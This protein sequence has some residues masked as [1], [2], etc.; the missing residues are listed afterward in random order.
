MQSS[1]AGIETIKSFS[2]EPSQRREW[3]NLA[4]KSIRRNSARQV[5]N[6]LVTNLNNTVQQIMTI[7]LV[8]AG[9]MLVLDG[10][11]SAGAIISCNMLAGKVV[12][13]V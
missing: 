13:P 4:S 12:S 6:I 11:L 5:S 10:A 3:R 9:V 8:F 2:L 7:S 1:I